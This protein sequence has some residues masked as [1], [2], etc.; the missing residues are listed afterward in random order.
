MDIVRLHT[1][2]YTGTEVPPPRDAVT[3]QCADLR[4]EARFRD[5]GVELL[6]PDRT[7]S[8][9]AT[10]SASGAR[11][12]NETGTAFRTKGDSAVL[13]LSGTEPVDCV[14]TDARSPWVEARE[15]GVVFRAVGQ[16]PG[17]LAE[18]GPGE[19]PALRLVLD[20][21]RRS[22][23]ITE[24]R[25]LDEGRKGFRGM[26][27]GVAVELRILHRVC[28]DSMSGEAFDTRVELHVGHAVYTGCGRYL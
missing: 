2:A 20:Y 10:V 4:M 7:V 26:A 8:L 9:G 12:A 13:I 11:Y 22:L 23:E 28:Y 17:W 27:E 16:E 14:V 24:S 6:L 19:P 1:S 21:G 3:Y 15:R 5:D 25:P 18:A